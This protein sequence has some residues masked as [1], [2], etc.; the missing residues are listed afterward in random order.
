MNY[1]NLYQTLQPQEKSVKDSLAS[2]QKLF[3]AASRETESGD[4]K[5]LTR[6]IG[7]MAEAALA[8]SSALEDIKDNLG[9]FDT[10]TYFESGDFAAQ[11]LEACQEKGVDVRGDF[12]VYEMFPYRVKLETGV[13]TCALPISA[14]KN[15]TRLLSMPSL[16]PASC[17]MP[18]NWPY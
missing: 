9:S 7:S 1:E 8:L 18:T 3:K 6:D 10:K 11:M 15:S 5:S 16:L 4:I 2:L 14:R 13:L 17:L 12:P